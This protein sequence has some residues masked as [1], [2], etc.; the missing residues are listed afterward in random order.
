[1][2]IAI[3][4]AEKKDFTKK[5]IAEKIG[6]FHHKWTESDD[7]KKSPQC[8]TIRDLS[9]TIISLKKIGPYEAIATFYGSRYEKKE[10]E[11]MKKIIFNVLSEL[12]EK[13]I[14]PELP[15]KEIIP[16]L[17]KDFPKC[18]HS[19]SVKR[20]FY[21]SK[22][23]FENGRHIIITGKQGDGLTQIAKWIAEYNSKNKQNFCFVFTPETSVS[24]LLGKFIPNSKIDSGN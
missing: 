1:M 11:I 14:I 4:I 6:E 10:K 8:F 13:K 15:K 21:Y 17:P 20:A 16:D 18:Y 7:S 12:C 22:I 19:L 3:Q 24:D 2:K 9:S 5:E 23:A